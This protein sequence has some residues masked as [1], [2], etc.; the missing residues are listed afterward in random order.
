MD[1]IKIFTEKCTRI[2]NTDMNNKNIYPGCKNGIWQNLEN[3]KYLEILEA[4]TSKQAERKENDQRTRKLMT[5]HKALHPSNDIVM[6]GL[7][8][9]RK[10]FAGFED[11]VDA[12]I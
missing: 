11:N 12:S 1:D 10:E 8:K 6:Y 3:Y 9:E 7:R 5:M 2:E 4:V